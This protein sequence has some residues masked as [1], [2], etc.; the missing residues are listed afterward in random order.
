MAYGTLT[1]GN[2]VEESRFLETSC[3]QI[4]KLGFWD[5][6]LEKFSSDLY[7]NDKSILPTRLSDSRFLEQVQP[8]RSILLA[9]PIM[10]MFLSWSRANKIQSS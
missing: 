8:S 1:K 5:S 7:Y 4:V 10:I 9:L 2:E 6:G 3:E